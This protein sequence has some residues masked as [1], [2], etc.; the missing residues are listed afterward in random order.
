MDAF[1]DIETRCDYGITKAM[2]KRRQP[3]SYLQTPVD[4]DHLK[5]ST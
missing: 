3:S 4:V 5:L 1:A 2:V